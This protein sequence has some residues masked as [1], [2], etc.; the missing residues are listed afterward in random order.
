MQILDFG[1][2]LELGSLVTCNSNMIKQYHVQ[3]YSMSL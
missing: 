1:D 2:N 3:V